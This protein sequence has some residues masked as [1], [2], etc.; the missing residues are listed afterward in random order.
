MTVP[1]G[2]VSPALLPNL[3]AWQRGDVV[4]VSAT[5]DASGA[6]IRTAQRVSLN[7]LMVQG[8][9]WSHAAIYVGKGQIVDAC[10]G[11]PVAC[12][13][14]WE[15]CSTRA[16]TVRRIDDPSV[17][18]KDVTAIA[19]AALSYVGKPYSAIEAVLSKL[20]RGRKPRPDRLICSTLVGL[21]IQDGTGVDLS[22]SP[23]HRPLFPGVIAEHPAL[24]TVLLEWCEHMNIKLAREGRL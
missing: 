5:A 11:Q 21:A 8:H 24:Q 18:L 14:V 23:E 1:A 7:R 10:F 19:D 3:D 13:S 4:L 9:A 17:P 6:L 22:A 12:R 2:W 20:V 16:L 15:Y